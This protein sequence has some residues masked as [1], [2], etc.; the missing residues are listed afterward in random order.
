[1]RDAPDADATRR[2]RY[3]NAN[4]TPSTRDA[5][6]ESDADLE[7]RRRRRA[8]VFGDLLPDTTTDERDAAEHDHIR[9]G[10]D[11][12]LRRNVPPHHPG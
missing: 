12:E 7:S 6:P 3:A 10:V 8:A 5:D 2:T 1:M 9:S 4:A 11:R